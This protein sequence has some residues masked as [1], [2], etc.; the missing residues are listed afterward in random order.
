MNE[1]LFDLTGKIGV[2][3]GAARG[4]GQAAAVGLAAYGTD[5]AAVDLDCERC[6]ATIGQIGDLGRR[7]T[8]YACDVG[9]EE[10]VH[11]TVAQIQQDFGRVDILVNIAGITA[12]IS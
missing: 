12:R 5:I 6:A 4:L 1:N 7:A 11:T 8:G 3:T 10:M 2:V 9:N